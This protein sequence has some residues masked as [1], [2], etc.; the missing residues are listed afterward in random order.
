MKQLHVFRIRRLPEMAVILAVLLITGLI[1]SFIL[2]TACQADLQTTVANTVTIQPGADVVWQPGSVALTAGNAPIFSGNAFTANSG[3]RVRL[4]G[5]SP[6]TLIFPSM[7]GN[8]GLVF[9]GGK[10]QVREPPAR[11]EST[12]YFCGARNTTPDHPN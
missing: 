5:T 2:A 4:N 12:I 10:L 8:A 3:A 1:A 7:Y 9:N 6:E 11:I